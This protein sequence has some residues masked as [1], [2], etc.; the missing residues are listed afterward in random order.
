MNWELF[1]TVSAKSHYII[2]PAMLIALAAVIIYL[3]RPKQYKGQYLIFTHTLAS[4]LQYL[5]SIVVVLWNGY[6]PNINS[7][8]VLSIN[9]FLII[10]GL[11]CTIF[12]L[13]ITTKPQYKKIISSCL[14]A[15][16]GIS[17]TSIFFYYKDSLS[18]ILLYSESVLIIFSALLYYIQLFN[19]I[20]EK[21]ILKDPSF[22]I[23]SGMAFVILC[24]LPLAI[25]DDYIRNNFR[26]LINTILIIPYTT[27]IILH[28]IYLIA[29][30]C[31]LKNTN[32]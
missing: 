26:S 12:I 15:F 19:T 2:I 17:F 1:H 22:L 20:S 27:Y 4:L 29:V 14:V 9:I 32:S 7:V 10:E 23:V 25:F 24:N 21:S 18:N 13:G 6:F 5:F 3:I 11:C 8:Q 28:G 30:L 31:K 16:I